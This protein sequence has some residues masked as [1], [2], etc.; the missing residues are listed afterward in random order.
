MPIY[1][2][3]GDGGET[4]LATGKRVSKNSKVIRALG[5]L[6]ELISSLGVLKAFAKKSAD[7][8][9]L[10]TLQKNLFQICA[11]LAGAKSTPL[12]NSGIEFLEKEID[13]RESKLP[14]IKNF[15]LPGNDKF[16][17]FAHMARAVCR[18]AERSL[19]ALNEKQKISP[20]ILAYINR[21]SDLLFMMAETRK[22]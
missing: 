6:D 1:T 13:R 4:C 20:E 19:A 14:P 16:T 9:L 8:K 22:N 7:K 18:R 17:A 12:T 10:I 5:E 3:K 15:I 11:I 2:K 21:L